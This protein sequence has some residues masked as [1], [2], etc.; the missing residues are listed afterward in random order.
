MTLSNQSKQLFRTLANTVV[1]WVWHMH[2]IRVVVESTWRL[3][4][5][6]V[7]SNKHPFEALRRTDEDG[8]HVMSF[9]F[10]AFFRLS[11]LPPS[12]PG[13]LAMAA[14]D[15]DDSSKVLCL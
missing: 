7:H 4:C 15:T 11:V 14:D 3:L 1:G 2:Q 12:M 13:K 8:R 6:S 5:A 10:F 9:S